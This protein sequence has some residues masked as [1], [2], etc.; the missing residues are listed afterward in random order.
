[1]QCLMISVSSCG[2]LL[3]KVDTTLLKLAFIR[4][5]LCNIEFPRII[6]CVCAFKSV[7]TYWN[8]YG[9]IFSKY[10]ITFQI[11]CIFH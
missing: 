11:N 5:N 9:Y 4:Q 1:M 2:V 10:V 8:V 6:S 7:D 3:L